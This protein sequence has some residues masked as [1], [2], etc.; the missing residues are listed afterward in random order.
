MVE[1]RGLG[2]HRSLDRQCDVD[3]RALCL[4]CREGDVL[5]HAPPAVD[6]L[7]LPGD[8][9]VRSVNGKTAEGGR[10]TGANRPRGPLGCCEFGPTDAPPCEAPFTSEGC[11][12]RGG[13]W[14][15]D[16]ATTEFGCHGG[17]PRSSRGCS[18]VRVKR[19][20]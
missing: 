2:H 4:A 20:R 12:A 18:F 15:E 17:M 19:S 10:D 13:R 11:S 9:A 7:L 5:G 14:F 6:R 16:C 8:V 3:D 1:P